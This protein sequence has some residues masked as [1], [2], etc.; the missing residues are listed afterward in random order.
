[1]YTKKRPLNQQADAWKNL[2][3]GLFVS[4]MDEHT[5][6]HVDTSAQPFVDQNGAGDDPLAFIDL[7]SLEVIA[8]W[9]GGTS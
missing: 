4:R 2:G 6:K 1:M 8:H 5:L 9:A 3:K 7:Y